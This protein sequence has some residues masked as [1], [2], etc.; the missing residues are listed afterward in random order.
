MERKVNELDRETVIVLQFLDTP[1]DEVAPGS[2]EIRKYFKRSNSGI[3][4]SLRVQLFQSLN[5]SRLS[6]AGKSNRILR[7]LAGESQES[8]RDGNCPNVGFIIASDSF[9]ARTV[10]NSVRG[11]RFNA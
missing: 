5:R 10:N 2:N 7:L 11:I 1:G 9:V 8:S 6:K 4:T 3:K